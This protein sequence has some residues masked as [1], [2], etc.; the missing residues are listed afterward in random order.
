MKEYTEVLS[1]RLRLTHLRGATA[2]TTDALLLAAF[3]P[4]TEGPSLELGAGCGVVSLVAASHGR[5]CR[6]VL[7]ER[8]A[9][10]SALS[11]RNILDNGYGG[12]FTALCCD[13]RDYFPAERFAVILANPP[14]RRAG[15]GRGAADPLCDIAR[16]ERAGTILDFC[17]AGARLLTEDGDF[18]LVFPISRRQ[19]LY[20]ATREVGLYPREEVTVLPYPGGTAKLFLLRATRAA[21]PLLSHRITLAGAPGGEPTEA[22]R[23]LY[24]DGCLLTEGEIS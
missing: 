3:L 7:C 15:E 24:R 13:L 12:R 6:G 4:V 11:H 14:Y 10:L 16:F 20:A 8:D 21:G 1:E 17:R 2:T 22:A 18:C 9:T 5:L 23:A 19:E